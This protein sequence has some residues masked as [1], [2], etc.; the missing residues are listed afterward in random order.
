M[1]KGHFDA[2]GVIPDIQDPR[3]TLVPGYFQQSLRPF[4]KTFSP[5]NRL[6]LHMDADLYS[7]TLYV[8]MNMDPFIK[9]GTLITFDEFIG[10]DEFPA[11]IHYAASCIRQWRYV[12]AK[13]TYGQMAVV[14]RE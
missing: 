8:L 11:F 13:H 4:L 14:I 9:P 10:V 5:R 1:K 3:V 2:G 7:S 12:G 6:V